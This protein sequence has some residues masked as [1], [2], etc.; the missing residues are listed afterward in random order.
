MAVERDRDG[1]QRTRASLPHRRPQDLTVTEVHTVEE[2]DGDDR[3]VVP[4]RQRSESLAALHEGKRNERARR[5][6]IRGGRAE[7]RGLR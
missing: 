7:V 1:G 3:S 2:P 6:R 5:T 4:E